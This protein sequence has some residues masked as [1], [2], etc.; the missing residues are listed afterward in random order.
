MRAN[1]NAFI[2]YIKLISAI[3][4]ECLNNAPPLSSFDSF[5]ENVTKTIINLTS[6][7]SIQAYY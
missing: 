5:K 4:T 7:S 3:S 6:T 2:N 1:N